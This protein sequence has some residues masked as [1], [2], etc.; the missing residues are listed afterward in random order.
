MTQK[1][2]IPMF[3]HICNIKNIHIILKTKQA[4]YIPKYIKNYQVI[5]PYILTTHI[6][7]NDCDKINADSYIENGYIYSEVY[8]HKLIDSMENMI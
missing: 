3:F 2:I 7:I 1:I 4:D 8:L 6:N 5:T